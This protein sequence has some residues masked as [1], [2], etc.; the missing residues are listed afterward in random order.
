LVE[1]DLVDELHLM[2]F[3]VLLGRGKRIFGSTSDKKALR[4]VDSKPVGEGVV[5][6]IYQPAGDSARSGSS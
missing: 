6:L 4:L 3:P 5:I 1:H 2:V